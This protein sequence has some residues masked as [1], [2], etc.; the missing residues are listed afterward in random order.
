MLS[1]HYLISDI[2]IDNANKFSGWVEVCTLHSPKQKW[3]EIPSISTLLKIFKLKLEPIDLVLCSENSVLSRENLPKSVKKTFLQKLFTVFRRLES[4]P[5]T[6]SK[7]FKDQ[8]STITP[9]W[10]TNQQSTVPSAWSNDPR[11]ST[12]T[13]WSSNQWPTAASAWP[14]NQR[15]T[16]PSAWSGHNRPTTPSVWSANQSRMSTP[17]PHNNFYSYMLVLCFICIL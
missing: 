1:Q 7:W 13:A 12:P 14:T 8:R 6:P 3:L 5:T 9:P 17:A 15:P 2:Y 11:P 16:T 4:R 10:T